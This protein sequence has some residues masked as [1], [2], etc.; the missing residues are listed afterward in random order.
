MNPAL[1]LQPTNGSRRRRVI[2]PLVIL[3]TAVGIML[4]SNPGEAHQERVAA[5]TAAAEHVCNPESAPS[6]IVWPS[7]VLRTMFETHAAD[8]CEGG[9]VTKLT[10]RPQPADEDAVVIGPLGQPALAVRFLSDAAELTVV[11]VRLI[12]SAP[13]AESETAGR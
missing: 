6:D 2:A 3:A 7:P 13:P 1:D 9:R 8:W 11:E 5:L 12:E 10:V 4:W